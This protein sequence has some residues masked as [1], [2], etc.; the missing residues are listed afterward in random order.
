MPGAV[1]HQLKQHPTF[2]SVLPT[3]ITN[4]SAKRLKEREQSTSMVSHPV[5]NLK[6]G[7]WWRGFA[8]LKPSAL[9]RKRVSVLGHRSPLSALSLIPDHHRFVVAFPPPPP[10]P[11][12]QPTHPLPK[13]K[14]GWWLEIKR[15]DKAEF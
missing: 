13:K 15:K 12:L 9:K 10:P 5:Q 1:W 14:K 3:L 6:N 8:C 4:N 11:T 2:L 7:K